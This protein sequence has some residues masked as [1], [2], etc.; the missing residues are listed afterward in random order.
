MLRNDVL[1]SIY[2]PY[3]NEGEG[4]AIRRSWKYL[5]SVSEWKF[6]QRYLTKNC[7]LNDE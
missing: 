7:T 1:K 6:T 5:S 3:Y 2:D 4:V